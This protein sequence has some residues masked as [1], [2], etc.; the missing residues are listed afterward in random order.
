MALLSTAKFNGRF[1]KIDPKLLAKLDSD[2]QEYLRNYLFH[3]NEQEKIINSATTWRYLL[4]GQNHTK[5][6][7]VIAKKLGGRKVLHQVAVDFFD[8]TDFFFETPS[9]DPRKHFKTAEEAKE[10]L[11][12]WI[13]ARSEEL[14]QPTFPLREQLTNTVGLP[15]P[16]TLKI[17]TGKPAT[18]VY[19]ELF[20]EG[21]I[22][23]RFTKPTSPKISG[24]H[25]NFE[26]T[27]SHRR[28][29]E[30]NHNVGYRYLK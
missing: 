29:T 19:R 2:D 13:I 6:S 22:P 21:R 26:P 17:L 3:C 1:K 8:G 27:T 14:G 24:K 12:A 18:K 28:R 20:E 23:F 7:G 30:Y 25:N 16:T 4:R 5:L 10:A 15:S 9:L 11:A